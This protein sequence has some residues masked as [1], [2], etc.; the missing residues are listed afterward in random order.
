MFI[1]PNHLPDAILSIASVQDFSEK[2]RISFGLFLHDRRKG[3]GVFPRPTQSGGDIVYDV[4]FAQRRKLNLGEVGIL[5]SNPSQCGER[6]D[7]LSIDVLDHRPHSLPEHFF[8]TVRHLGNIDEQPG[9]PSP[10]P[11]VPSSCLR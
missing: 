2:K 11:R 5:R 4:V 8:L 6:G 7:N 9:P 1:C 10:P 3:D